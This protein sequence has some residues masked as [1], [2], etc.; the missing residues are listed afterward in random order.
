[1][2]DLKYVKWFL[3]LVLVFLPYCEEDESAEIAATWLIP[4]NEVM[5][6]GPG[7]DG[8]IAIS[9]PVFIPLEQTSFLF[10]NDLVVGIQVGNVFRAFPHVILDHHEIV[11]YSIDEKSI[12]LSYCP[13]TGSAMAWDT[14]D[15]STDKTFGVSGLLYNSNLILYDRETDSNWSQML[16]LCVNGERGGQKAEEIQVLETT[17]LTWR[18]LY[19]QSM[20]MSNDTGYNYNYTVY[21]YGNYKTSDALIFPVNN[22]DE[23]LHKKERV[24]GVII[25]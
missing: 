14:S 23:R 3:I 4:E 24:H 17:W 20:V 8:I 5:D 10:D 2:R 1:M 11:N 9:N 13:L 19:P 12:T 25:Q 6:G 21:P 16:Y 18:Q 22:S 15:F 7:K